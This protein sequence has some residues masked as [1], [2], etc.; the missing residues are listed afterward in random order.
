MAQYTGIQGSNILIVS[1]DPA[2][3]VEGQIWYNTTSNLLKGYTYGTASWAS[4]GNLSTSRDVLGGA[5]ATTSAVLAIGGYPPA[6]GGIGTNAVES[7]NGTS[8]TGAPNLATAAYGQGTTGTQTA[9]LSIGGYSGAT[10]NNTQTYNGSSW[11]NTTVYPSF[12]SSNATAGTNTAAINVGGYDGAWSVLTKTWNGSTYS[13]GADIPATAGRQN[14]GIAGNQTAALYFGGAIP[15]PNA[16]ESILYNG[17]TWTTTPSLNTAKYTSGSG[18]ATAALAPGGYISTTDSFTLVAEVYNGTTWT[19]SASNPITHGYQVSQNRA[20][21][22]PGA[23]GLIFGGGNYPA[24][25]F[26]N[27]TQQFTGAV[28]TTKTLTTS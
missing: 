11:T 13:A 6:Q 27:T 25:G 22:T 20:S 12:I 5:G 21:N 18:T 26:S 14:A 10:L 7:Y 2:N 9:A 15:S 1:S 8:W 4:G 3:P 19:N 16:S 23:S 17:L 28:L 24:P